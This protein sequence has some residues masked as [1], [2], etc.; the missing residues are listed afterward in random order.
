MFKTFRNI[1]ICLSLVIVS[2][3]EE[4]KSNS[5]LDNVDLY[6]LTLED[7][8]NIQ[9][10]TP[11]K[12][13]EPYFQSSSAIYVVTAEDMK[14]R[15]I[16]NVVEALRGVPGV[17][18][19][20]RS[21]D[22][23][24]V[25]VRGFDNQFSNKLLVLVD[26][27]SVYTPVFSGVYWGAINYPVE[28]L[29]Q[30]EVIRGPGASIWGA[31][32]V[33]GVINIKTK[34][35]KDT[36]GTFLEAEYGTE[37]QGYTFRHGF[38]LDEDKITM[39]IYGQFQN[40]EP[41]DYGESGAPAGEKEDDW[42]NKMAGMRL[43]Y[44]IT[45]F[46]SLR[47]SV[48]GYSQ[49]YHA[50]N[51][52]ATRSFHDSQTDGINTILEYGKEI[53]ERE[54]FKLKFYYDYF[55]LN[56]EDKLS[57]KTHTWDTSAIYNIVVGERHH[58]SLGGGVRFINT[59]ADDTSGFVNIQP[60]RES[61]TNY[62]LFIQD[63]ITLVE[64]KLFLTLGAKADFLEYTG[65]EFQPSIKLS[66]LPDEN[67]TIWLSASQSARSPSRYE[68]NSTVLFA[69]NGNHKADSEEL[70]AYEVGYRHK[71]DQAIMTITAFYY[72]YDELIQYNLINGNLENEGSAESHGVE[73][74]FDYKAL[75]NWTLRASYTYLN[76]DF[77]KPE[78]H[79]DILFYEDKYAHNKF[80]LHSYWNVTDDIDWD[81]SLY[82]SDSRETYGAT[83]RVVN[84]Y[85]KLDS[86]ISWE[87]NKNLECYIL[88]KNLLDGSTRESGQ[89]SEVPRSASFGVVYRF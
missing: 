39:R 37:S 69:I 88:L 43:D 21:T 49:N 30:I 86:R 61:L 79:E 48:D 47:F 78:T 11:S 53:S 9:V 31:N 41:L 26:G 70:K 32:A 36:L 85:F 50:L 54:S 46:D 60:R 57:H 24:E 65:M 56:E 87:V 15:G 19:S 66:Y 40:I 83:N 7:L 44:A 18:V 8:M 1:L 71:F 75:E 76:A 45:N 22:S 23:W 25:S 52:L 67:N 38:S 5:A 42:D 20:R 82:Y 34:N 28:D 74:A 12:K 59:I 62:N 81:L 4:K 63:K 55:H 64:S 77:D 27:R 3:G 14:R 17:Q 80:A 29:E 73:F 89:T 51:S 13:K 2:K 68:N 33:N 58:L 10:V 72:E 16:R 35:S 6:D 84:A